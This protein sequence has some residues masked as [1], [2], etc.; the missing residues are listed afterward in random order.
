MNSAAWYYLKIS[1]GKQIRIKVNLL[2]IKNNSGQQTG[3][4]DI[5]TFLHFF[6]ILM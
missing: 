1:T 6:C 3:N 5:N 2:Q 4:S